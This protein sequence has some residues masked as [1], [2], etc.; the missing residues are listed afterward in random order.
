MR[1]MNGSGLDMA[2]IISPIY[3]S[4]LDRANECSLARKL[5]KAWGVM[6]LKNPYHYGL[7]W[8]V[9]KEGKLVGFLETKQRKMTWEESG[10]YFLG[11]K[12]FIWGQM[13]KQQTN[14]DWVFVVRFING[15]YMV[16]PVQ[17]WGNGYVKHN[18]RLDRGDPN[19][20]E[21][22]VHFPMRIMKKIGKHEQ[23]NT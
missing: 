10:E 20:I 3:E 15:D 16:K 17:M 8:S 4:A 13:L 14:L 12:K 22:C 1:C 23:R 5:M 21:P 18:G 2:K 9:Y 6:T 7:D 19:D 11:M